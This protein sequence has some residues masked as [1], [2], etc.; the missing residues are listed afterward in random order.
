MK[1]LTGPARA[2]MWLLAQCFKAKKLLL[3]ATCCRNSVFLHRG[4]KIVVTP[5]TESQTLCG[6]V[7]TLKK[8]SHAQLFLDL[9]V[10]NPAILQNILCNV[11]VAVW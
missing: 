2:N 1:Q 7:A 8:L 11:Y 6:V 10:L 9:R 3:V 4:K 5:V